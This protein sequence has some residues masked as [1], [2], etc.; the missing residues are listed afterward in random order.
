MVIRLSS[1]GLFYV[2]L[3][4]AVVQ[5]K[6]VEEKQH[7]PPHLKLV[8]SDGVAQLILV[9]TWLEQGAGHQ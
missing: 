1:V 2:F 5:T 7:L 3:V 4:D 6:K 8:L 9:E